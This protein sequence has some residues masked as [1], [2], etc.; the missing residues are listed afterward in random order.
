MTTTGPPP[1]AGPPDTRPLNRFEVPLP[2]PLDLDASLAF[3]RRNGDDLFDRW[4]GHTLLR[5]LTVANHHVPVAM[6]PLRDRHTPVLVVAAVQQPGKPVPAETL[7]RAVAEQFIADEPA[8]QRLLAGDPVLARLDAK[9]PGIRP[10]RLTDPLYSLVRSISAQQVNLRWAVTLR[11]RLARHFAT[12]HRIGEHTV[13]NIDKDRL[14]GASVAELRELQFSTR[15][16]TYLIE[17]AA[18]AAAGQLDLAELRDL[19]DTEVIR[20]LTAL[21]GVGR[22]TAEWFLARVLARP[23]VVAG[24][25]VVR[26]TVGWTYGRTDTPTEDQ[27]RQL[28]SHWGPAALIAQQLVL[29]TAGGPRE[30]GPGG[31]R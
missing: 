14:A 25:L 19:P 3:L 29:E 2:A 22:W 23:V 26:K 31:M 18:T 11:T 20:R 9:H 28:T 24:D 6:H 5:V 17:A 1:S 12:A 21:H 4:D 30:S 8:W 13:H 7:R 10:L 27:T 15:K 16:A